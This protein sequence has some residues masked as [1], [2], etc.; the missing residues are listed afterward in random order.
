[1]QKFSFNKFESWTVFLM[2]ICLLSSLAYFFY[3]SSAFKHLDTVFLFESSL[4]I[5]SHGKPTTSTGGTF[6]DFQKVAASAA[7]IASICT[8]TFDRALL[9][10]Y[11]ILDNHAYYAI[12]PI[13]GAVAIVGPEIAFGILKSFSYLT[14]LFVPFIFF[15]REGVSVL[16]S[17]AFILCVVLY[18]GYSYS[19]VGDDYLDRLYMPFAMLA[20]YFLNEIL[21]KNSE[22]NRFIV[23]AF[24][25]SII[26][27][28]MFTERSAIMMIGL[29][30]FVLSFSSHIRKNS[31]TRNISFLLLTLLIAHLFVYFKYIQ[32][33]TMSGG[34]LQDT[35][36][37]KWNLTNPQV[38]T[39]FW[40]NFLLMG[41]FTLLSNGRYIILVIGSMLPNLFFSVGGAELTG[42]TT[43]YH[44]MYI[45]FLIFGA[46]IGFLRAEQY[47]NQK[48]GKALFALC[49]AGSALAVASSLNP[50]T[51][52]FKFNSF[53]SVKQG[54]LGQFYRFYIEPEK[55]YERLA[56]LLRNDLEKIIPEGASVS[57]IEGAMP[58]LYNSRLL[59][60]FPIGL[61][62]ADYLV[63]AGEVSG[64]SVTRIDGAR[65]Y[66]GKVQTDELNKCLLDFRIERDFALIKTIPSFSILIF[67]RRSSL[68]KFAQ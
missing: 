5:L 40:V 30:V 23:G 19:A 14:L 57:V 62:T 9:P 16:G 42:W 53:A 28:S 61:S 50:E 25:V 27:A 37:F 49:V 22:P 43:H 3:I 33:G 55:S 44:S 15:R 1:M 31:L 48:K 58:S 68:I 11:N 41:V 17:V 36:I 56:S 13:A 59:S 18:P 4:S 12:Y 32:T 21:Y 26:I 54:F 52:S 67:K 65:S 45:P 10:S 6:F 64:N 7:S 34:N 60:L 38:R 63:V 35:F 8:A 2:G 51:G 39:F 20:L 24:F 46:S 47:F 29:V 66:Q